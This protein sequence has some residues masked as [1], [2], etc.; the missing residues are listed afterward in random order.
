MKM[1]SNQKWFGL[2]G[3]AGLS[4]A[5]VAMPAAAADEIDELRGMVNS[6]KA[7]VDVLRSERESDWLTEHRAEEIKGLVQDVLA[8][9]DTRASLQGSTMNAGYDGGF[10]IRTSDDTFKLKINGQLQVRWDFNHRKAEENEQSNAY[11]FEV[12]RFKLKFSGYVIDPSWA[13]K[14]TIVNTRNARVGGSAGF[15][16][17]DAWIQKKFDNDMYVKVGQ[18]KAPF[19]R[20]ELV[21]SSAQLAVERSMVNN[22]FTYGWTQGIELGWSNDW[23]SLKGMYNDGPLRLNGQAYSTGENSL[24]ARAEVKLA[25]DWKMFKSLSGFGNTDFGLMIGGA[26]EWY[27]L[28]NPNNFLEYGN[29]DGRNNIGFTADISM[30]GSG[31]TA[32]SYFVWGNGS[33]HQAVYDQNTVDSWGWVVQGGIMPV[34]DIELF[35]RYELG[36]ID[37]YRGTLDL[38]GTTGH[39]STLTVGANWWPTGD[40]HVKISADFGYAFSNLA[41]GPGANLDPGNPSTNPGSADWV[42]SGTGWDADYR[43]ESGQFLI[44]AQMQL[45][46]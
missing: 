35:A 7:E 32:F 40:K 42:S 22:A 33:N 14:F 26:V 19:L 25:G 36:D 6:L 15:Y 29:V 20:E 10:Y 37:D 3:A 2:M 21:S 23:L 9:A 45:L 46:F 12:R 27:N 16:A 28:D 43:N 8:D 17:E 34:D 39:N 18:F 30:G 1:T 11:G 24:T 38:P 44:R 5:S 31:W 4:L 41:D 13:Y